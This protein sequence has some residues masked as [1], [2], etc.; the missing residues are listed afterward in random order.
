VN[1]WIRLKS[2]LAFLRRH[3]AERYR[4]CQ[5][6][7]LLR[8]TGK[9]REAQS[10]L[11]WAPGGMPLLLHVE[12]A[13]ANA[14]RLR[15]HRVHA[16]ICDGSYRAC[17]RREI[18]DNVPIRNWSAS[19]LQC[20]RD[21]SKVLR[22]LRVPFSYV[23]DFVTDK[24]LKELRNKSDTVTWETLDALRSNG[25]D[26]GKNAKSAVIRYLKGHDFT[27]DQEL[28]REY[29]FSAL[30]C[31]AA[32]K[33]A[34]EDTQATHMVMSHGIYVDWGPAL[35]VALKRGV[36][37]TAWMASY[38]TARFYLKRIDD[39]ERTDKHRLS[40]HA[41]K[42]VRGIQLSKDENAC[43]D[44]YLIR[45]YKEHVSFDMRHHVEYGSDIEALRRQ[46][47]GN[48]EKPIWG[49]FTHVNWDAV[50][51]KAPMIYPSFDE[52][53]VDTV[54]EIVEIDDV[55]WIIKIHPGETW[56]NPE[57]GA[58]R[59]IEKRFPN[60]PAHIRIVTGEAEIKPLEF[61]ELIDGAVTVYGTPGLEVA[62]LGKPVILAGEAHYGGKGFTYEASTVADYMILL[63]KAASLGSLTEEQRSLAEKYAYCY[64]IQRQI[65]FPVVK[66]ANSSWWSFQH[67]KRSLLL[68]GKDPFIDFICDRLV[69]GKDFILDEELVA[70]ADKY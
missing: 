17:M 30:V 13:L 28:V 22:T 5:M 39:S 38:L 31:A 47:V 69:D 33:R 27:G 36:A 65:P 58:R 54:N 1:V 59:L 53:L 70:L 55:N 60:L 21:T 29:A 10:V 20:K 42:R 44:D 11:F 2:W 49:I 45:R 61:Y 68:P 51:A 57:T 56:N 52:W 66:D 32:A 37:V 50:S 26:V 19:C 3:T 14:L 63:S 12:G 9:T 41:W 64:F 48:S 25:L 4:A 62:L 6:L 16:V 35:K 40:K 8:G 34:I 15:G 46:Y 18:T 67:D 7:L 24:T 43:L 23:S